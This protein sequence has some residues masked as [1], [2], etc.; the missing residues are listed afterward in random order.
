[1]TDAFG[2]TSRD[3]VDSSL[4][5]LLNALAPRDGSASKE[6]ANA[7]LAVVD[8]ARPNDEIEAMLVSQM[9]VTHALAMNFL[10]R[11]HLNE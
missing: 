10:G 7:V 3:F 11:A 4:A 6:T 2:T 8:G 9:A 5:Q 1:V